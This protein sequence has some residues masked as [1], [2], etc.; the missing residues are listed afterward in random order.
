[1]REGLSLRIFQDCDLDLMKVW[2]HEDYVAKWY[3]HPLSWINEITHRT[4]VF[5]WIHH[6]IVVYQG[7]SIGFCQFYEYGQSGEDWHG[8]VELDGT[9]SIDYLIGDRNYLGKGFGRDTICLLID[10]IKK[11][12][13][14]KH[15]IVK[16]EEENKASCNTLLSGGFSYD[17]ENELYL[18][19][20]DKNEDSRVI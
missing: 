20:L 7:L 1:M 5:S 16:P 17:A 15:I 4:D 10:E 12:D 19:H 11:Q 9:Y 18:L 14:A 8:N 13:G 3:E 6:F 2:L